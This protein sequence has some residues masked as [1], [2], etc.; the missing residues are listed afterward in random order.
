MTRNKPNDL[1]DLPRMV[2]DRDE[3]ARRRSGGNGGNSGGQP[4][5]PGAQGP[6]HQ[7]GPSL[8]PLYTLFLLLAGGT[9]YLGYEYWQARAQLQAAEVAR[10][11]ASDR[12]SELENQLS[13]TD[14]SLTLNESAIQ[15]NF[16][17]ISAEIRRLWDV[18]DGRNREWIRENQSALAELTDLPEQVAALGERL[19]RQESQLAEVFDDLEDEIASRQA[20]SSNLQDAL[21]QLTGLYTS[22]AELQG[23]EDEIT[24]RLDIVSIRVEGAM[25]QTTAISQ[26]LNRLDE[27]LDAV[28]TQLQQEADARA[29]LS[30]SVSQLR[31]R[32]NLLEEGGIS[33]EFGDLI[34]RVEAIDIARTD[35]IQRLSNLQS[36]IADL[37]QRMESMNDN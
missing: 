11:E 15:S 33:D 29:S 5:P 7:G 34:E 31:S 35:T 37:R 22:V 18:A 10:A 2:P 1:S 36:Q 16:N 6:G 23:R 19:N 12:I 3:I 27:D 25:E 17:N 24:A 21:E 20:L 8:W 28:T 30:D 26:E 32:L 4:P 9:G 14:E 13:A